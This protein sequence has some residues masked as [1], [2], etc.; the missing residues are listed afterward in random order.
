M[1]KFLEL[2]DGRGDMGRSIGLR[3]N[4]VE[5]GDYFIQRELIPVDS[6]L[7]AFVMLPEKRNIQIKFQVDG[8]VFSR[9]EYY[10]DTVDCIKRWVMIKKACGITANDQLMNPVPLP[11]D[12]EEMEKRKAE[13]EAAKYEAK[14]KALRAKEEERLGIDF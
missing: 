1:G 7:D 11:M 12:A 13:A 2:R 5:E 3:R 10:K 9:V 14:A 4:D 8:R 6:I